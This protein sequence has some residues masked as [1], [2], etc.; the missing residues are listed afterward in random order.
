MARA[1]ATVLLVLPITLSL[2]TAD[3]ALAL[4][5]EAETPVESAESSENVVEV[6]GTR[7]LRGKR[8][9]V[10]RSEVSRPVAFRPAPGPRIP[11]RKP[12]RSEAGRE[13]R[14]RHGSLLR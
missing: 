3:D 13:R 8:V 7:K 11:S 14:I 1:I 4:H 5:C 9:R 6:R 2:S 12:V 10:Q